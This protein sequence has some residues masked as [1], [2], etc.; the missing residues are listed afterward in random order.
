MNSNSYHGELCKEDTLLVTFFE[1][2]STVRS[3]VLFSEAYPQIARTVIARYSR[4]PLEV[5]FPALERYLRKL[6]YP[7]SFKDPEFR[8]LKVEYC[9]EFKDPNTPIIK[10]KILKGLID[11][12]PLHPIVLTDNEANLH[13]LHE[14]I[15][16]LVL[17]ESSNNSRRNGRRLVRLYTSSELENL[18]KVLAS[19]ILN[20]TASTYIGNNYENRKE[21]KQRGR[22]RRS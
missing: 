9:Y 2:E 11:A 17:E 14:K 3:M 13:Q 4:F 1:I 19:T 8:I 12:S 20:K 16:R 18:W 7:Y 21:R 5:R 6:S 22:K 10:I 15:L